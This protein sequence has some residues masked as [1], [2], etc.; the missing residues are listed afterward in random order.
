MPCQ[1]KERRGKR[2]RETEREDEKQ[3]VV[4]CNGMCA[5]GGLGVLANL[6][7]AVNE[8]TLMTFFL[9]GELSLRAER[10]I[11]TCATQAA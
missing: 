1:Q 9:L 3:E 2:E 7:T 11:R 10:G 6:F 4:G 8:N 5:L